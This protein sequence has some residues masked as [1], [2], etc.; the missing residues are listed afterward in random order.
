MTMG[1]AA[2]AFALAATFWGALCAAHAQ[3]KPPLEAF[4]VLPDEAPSISPDGSH[5]ALI[6]GRPFTEAGL[7]Q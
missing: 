5:F 6:R 7:R 4:A 3:S 1:P 2:R